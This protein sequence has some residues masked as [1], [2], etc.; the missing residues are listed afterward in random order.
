[1]RGKNFFQRETKLFARRHGDNFRASCSRI[2]L[3]HGK[4]RNNDNGFVARLKIGFADQ[5]DGFVRPI[6]E[7]QF[8][9]TNSEVRSDDC[10]K[11]L[12]LGITCQLL[13]I[14]LSQPLHYS[15]RATNGVLIEIQPQS[16]R[17]FPAAGDTTLGCALPLVV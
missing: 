3:V 12:P 16:L 14:E 5:M 2:N 17:G 13:A 11:R 4:C 15:R 1:M 6:G 8:F 7:Q 9:R 10:L